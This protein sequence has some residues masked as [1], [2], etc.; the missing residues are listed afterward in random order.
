MYSLGGTLYHALT[1]HVPFEAPT[2]EEIANAHIQTPLTPPNQV[3]PEVTQATSDALVKAMAK[4]P[5]DRFQS[6]DEFTIALEASL[7]QLLVSSYS[8][9]Y[10]GGDTI[11]AQKGWWRR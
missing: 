9:V 1:G 10:Q 7:S 8:Q 11:R 2:I 6:Y 4:N 3:V 5:A